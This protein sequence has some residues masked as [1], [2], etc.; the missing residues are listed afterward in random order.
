MK[1]VIMAG[2]EGTRLRPLTSNIPKPMVPVVNKPIMQHIIEL[3]KKHNITDVAATLF[4]M[5]QVIKDYFGD[6][7]EFDVNIHYYVEKSPLGTAGSVKNAQDFLDDTFIVI[8]GDALTDI[9]LESAVKFHKRNNAL[10]TLILKKVTVPLEYGVVVT[11]QKGEITRFLEKPSWGEVFSDTVNTGI[12][13]LEPQVLDMFEKDKVFD[14]SKDLFPKILSQKLPIY[15]YVS[16]DY[17]C[18]IG[19]LKAYHQSHIDIMDNKVKIN[20]D[21][22]KTNDN[23][24]ISSYISN[25]CSIHGPCVIGKNVTIKDGSIIAPYSVI[26]DGAIIEKNN[27]ISRS[28]IWSNA[29]I[30]N[31]ATLNSSLICHRVNI[32]ENV[33]C[34]EYS[35]IGDNCVIEDSAVIKPNVKVWPNK[36]IESEVELNNNLVWGNKQSKSL[37][38]QRGI[39]GYIN[40]DITPEYSTKIAA[41]FGSISDRTKKI[42]ISYDGNA[43]SYMIYTA[44]IAGLLSSGVQVYSLNKLLT[45]MARQ[46]VKLYGLSGGIHIT[47]NPIE[48]DKVCIDFFDKLGLNISKGIERKIENTMAREDFARTDGSNIKEVVEF[49]E[50]GSF[51]IANVLNSVT[52][53]RLDLNVVVNSCSEYA[54]STVA[55]VVESLGCTVQTVKYDCNNNDEKFANYIRLLN[56]D[57][58][59]IISENAEKIV[60]FDESGR[61]ITDNEYLA[62]CSILLFKKYKHSTV[63]AP[64]WASNVLE[65]LASSYEG[66]IYR[67]KTS[68]VDIMEGLNKDAKN[69]ESKEEFDLVFDG[70]SG[71]LKILEFLH[72]NSIKLSDLLKMVPQIHLRQKE[73]Y[74]PWEQKGSV[75]RNLIQDKDNTKMELLEGV[76]L[77]N[78]HG[79]VLILPDAEKPICRIITEG[80]DEEF[81]QELCDIY[82][83]KITKMNK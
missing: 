9:D 50:F 83:E 23:V 18:D 21:G 35:V 56:S 38:G 61:V 69:L 68:T 46:A 25:D 2:G 28:I 33:R 42:S 19:D 80:D 64:L 39:N 11:D 12:Y 43:N 47:T 5:P 4:Y 54:L 73:V 41:A 66:S 45:P 63:V 17:W 57:I 81:A 48:N 75:M 1:A 76:K 24:W 78:E 22:K 7:S 31:N 20:I 51:Y 55:K 77:Y 27:N 72:T 40:I 60:I 49:K 70:I 82:V 13:I 26:G 67:T 29:F 59:V 58:G 53:G 10:A 62:L 14:F 30:G 6:G 34:E 74:C 71:L 44:M 15:G 3:L 32:K 16:N 79:W 37:F 8:S 65:K 52:V 36:I